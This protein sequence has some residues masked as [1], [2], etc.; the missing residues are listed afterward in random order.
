MKPAQEIHLVREN[1]TLALSLWRAAKNRLINPDLLLG[2]APDAVHNDTGRSEA[3][4]NRERA[5]LL[6]RS[7]ANQV[8]LPSPFRSSRPNEAWNP[9]SPATRWTRNPGPPVRPLLC[10]PDGRRHRPRHV[11][12]GLG[13]PAALPQAI[14][15]PARP[16]RVGCRRHP[17]HAGKLGPLWRS[18]QVPQFAGLLRRLGRPDALRGTR[19]AHPDR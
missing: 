6:T 3:S 17:R 8:R 13:L 4:L 19:T 9:C 5:E 12:A 16:L 14:R 1:L 7:G 11:L 18:G 10:L 15:R 2:D